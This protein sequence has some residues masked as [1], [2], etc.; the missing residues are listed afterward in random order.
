MNRSVEKLTLSVPDV[1][2]ALGLSRGA[3]YEAVR[4]GQIPSIKIGKRILI[5]VQALETLL[6]SCSPQTDIGSQCP[7]ID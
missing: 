2:I 3:A 1:A 6:A 4:C 7:K 5:P